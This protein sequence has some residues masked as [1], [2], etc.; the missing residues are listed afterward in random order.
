LL[1]HFIVNIFRIHF[2]PLFFIFLYVQPRTI[3]VGL[4]LNDDD[5]ECS[6]MRS[7]YWKVCQVFQI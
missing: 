6:M 5:N 3:N 4:R 7:P 1:K 2:A